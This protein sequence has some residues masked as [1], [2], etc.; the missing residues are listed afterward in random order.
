MY[1]LVEMSWWT[2]KKKKRIV[3]QPDCVS[4]CFC[5][6]ESIWF[7]PAGPEAAAALAAG[8]AEV[9]VLEATQG[10]A[11]GDVG[12]I[13]SSS[14]ANCCLIH[15][16]M[17]GFM[18]CNLST[19]YH[20]LTDRLQSTS[21]VVEILSHLPYFR[22]N[23]RCKLRLGF[24]C[25]FANPQSLVSSHFVSSQCVLKPFLCAVLLGLVK[26]LSSA[27]LVPDG[28]IP[29]PARSP[30][31]VRHGSPAP[32]LLLASHAHANLTHAPAPRSP[33]ADRP[34]ASPVP[35]PTP[36]SPAPRAR[37]LPKWSPSAA[38]VASPRRSRLVRNPAAAPPR[39]QRTET[40]SATNRLPALLLP[41]LRRAARSPRNGLPAPAPNLHPAP[42]PDPDP[43]PGPDPPPRT[44][45]YVP[46]I[47]CQSCKEWISDDSVH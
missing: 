37:A 43:G 23:L 22:A 20:G 38:P 9:A 32:N 16:L 6:T 13:S 29:G 36:A 12:P 3:W 28:T 30:G 18:C 42:S 2:L 10:L 21:F 19:Y 33:E 15:L 44:R 34:A 25:I 24:K 11:Q 5:N 40:K 41:R 4:V 17:V 47:M 1:R 27:G 35:D 26:F 39:L 7:S 46:F 14:F 8:A 45:P 31:P